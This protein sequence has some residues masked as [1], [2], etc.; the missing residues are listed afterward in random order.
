MSIRLD[1]LATSSGGAIERQG[2]KARTDK[3][4]LEVEK[5]LFASGQQPAPP[6]TI[7]AT[8]SRLAADTMQVGGIFGATGAHQVANGTPDAVRQSPAHPGA[9]ASRAVEA[10]REQS[11][12][13]RSAVAAPA[14][15]RSL[16]MSSTVAA[17][18]IAQREAVAGIVRLPASEGKLVP[19][20]SMREPEDISE[21]VADSAGVVAPTS[22]PQITYSLPKFGTPAAAALIDPVRDV[23]ALRDG[24]GDPMEAVHLD[25]AKTV[26]EDA[27][28]ASSPIVPPLADHAADIP[29]LTAQAVTT[30]DPAGR[31]AVPAWTQPRTQPNTQPLVQRQVQPQPQPQPQ[32]R[33]AAGTMVQAG[34]AAPVG[35]MGRTE[36]SAMEDPATL[37]ESIDPALMAAMA[38][39][40]PLPVHTG[41]SVPVA[42]AVQLPPVVGAT[43]SPVANVVPASSTAWPQQVLRAPG[44]G[45]VQPFASAGIAVPSP[46]H[47]GPAEPAARQPGSPAKAKA[48]GEPYALRNMHVVEGDEGV[49]AWIRDAQLTPRQGQAVAQAMAAQFVQ[50]GAVLGSL[51][52]NGRVYQQRIEPDHDDATQESDLAGVRRTTGAASEINIVKGAA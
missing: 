46:I 39:F 32:P 5:A 36:S 21:V 17:P 42:L 52:I 4:M 19:P 48:H 14:P 11:D 38:S 9:P 25:M 35:A 7:A 1:L 45:I 8:P 34:P 6:N 28:D 41:A 37:V 49:H 3:W 12:A 16:S 47:D 33:T 10:P 2:A 29:V 26:R 50:Q 40:I 18:A 20:L 44:F 24:P 31:M 23:L 22:A 43:V 27:A 51:T 30:T 15:A 13:A